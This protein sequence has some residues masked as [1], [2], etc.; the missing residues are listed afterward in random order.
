LVTSAVVFKLKLYDAAS[1]EHIEQLTGYKLTNQSIKSIDRP[2]SQ[3]EKSNFVALWQQRLRRVQG[4]IHK[5][6]DWLPGA[7][8][9]SG[10]AY[11][12]CVQLYRYFV[13]QSSEFCR[14]NPLCCFSTSVYCCKRIFSY[15]ISPETFGCTL[16]LSWTALTLGSWVRILLEERIYVPVY[17]LRCPVWIERRL[18]MGGSPIR[19]ILS[20]YLLRRFISEVKS[21][22]E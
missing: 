8:T 3:H 2:I 4:C 14:H 19:G 20:E 12:H 11:C 6:P 15:L 22:S 18:A 7:R 13:S 17:L 16:V 21:D 10:R 1:C 9:S 5:F